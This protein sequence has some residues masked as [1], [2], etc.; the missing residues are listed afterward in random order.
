MTDDIVSLLKERMDQCCTAMTPPRTICP[1]C[2]LDRDVISEIRKLRAS[3]LD[4]DGDFHALKK[5]FDRMRAKTE[6]P[7]PTVSASFEIPAQT[8]ANGWMPIA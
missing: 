2:A 3:L 4:C 7:Q 6:T 5:M 8:Y 1:D